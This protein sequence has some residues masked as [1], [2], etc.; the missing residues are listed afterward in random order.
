MDNNSLPTTII[1]SNINDYN[2]TDI[3]LPKNI[4]V[5]YSKVFDNCKKLSNFPSHVTSFGERGSKAFIKTYNE[6]N[7]ENPINNIS[8]GANRNIILDY[9]TEE[10]NHPLVLG[11]KTKISFKEIKK[12]NIYCL[13]FFFYFMYYSIFNTN[14][15]H[16]IFFLYIRNISL[17][18]KSIWI[19]KK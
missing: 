17:F 15:I 13:Y 2:L 9:L 6:N 12:E 8:I 19:C 5:I 1:Q 18:N 11:N 16:S 7:K 3:I 10:N 14:L 4:K